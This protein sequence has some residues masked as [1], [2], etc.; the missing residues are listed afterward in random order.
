MGRRWR[1][2]PAAT[3]RVR[4]ALW[5]EGDSPGPLP[6][7]GDSSPDRDRA[8]RAGEA[9]TGRKG[10]D[11]LRGEDGDRE[12]GNGEQNG[13]LRGIRPH[14]DREQMG[15]QLPWPSK[16]VAHAY[17]LCPDVKTRRQEHIPLG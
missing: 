12:R 7:R 10:P 8:R 16:H 1:S 15:R 17:S 3:A 5:Q 4:V 6:Q 2:W 9:R 14:Q 13:P 11:R